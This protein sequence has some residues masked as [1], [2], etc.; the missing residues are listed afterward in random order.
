MT[1]LL[2]QAAGRK[3]RV[4]LFD[5]EGIPGDWCVILDFDGSWTNVEV[6]KKKGAKRETQLLPLSSIRSIIFLKEGQ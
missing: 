2:R 4:S 3:V 1:R 5:G 6:V